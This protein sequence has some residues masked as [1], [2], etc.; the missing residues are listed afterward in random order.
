MSEGT[1]RLGQFLASHIQKQGAKLLS[2]GFKISEDKASEK[3][4]NALT[5]AAGAVEGFATIYR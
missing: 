2:S 5:I 4:Q 1:T 3:M